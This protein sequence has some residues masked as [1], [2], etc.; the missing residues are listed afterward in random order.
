VFGEFLGAGEVTGEEGLVRQS[1]HCRGV[2][3]PVG[4]GLGERRGLLV[5]AA[6]VGVSVFG[7]GEQAAHDA[8]PIGRLNSRLVAHNTV[9][10]DEHPDLGEASLLTT[11]MHGNDPQPFITVQLP[12]G[13]TLLNTWM[14]PP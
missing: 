10:Y 1:G 6:G 9:A 7:T 11:D 8:L 3:G 5:I 12:C 4:G 14:T 2:P 13:L